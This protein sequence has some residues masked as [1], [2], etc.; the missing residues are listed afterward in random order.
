MVRDRKRNDIPPQQLTRREWAIGIV[1]LII[2][3]ALLVMHF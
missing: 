2:W 3:V 1:G